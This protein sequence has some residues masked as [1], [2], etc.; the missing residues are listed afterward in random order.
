MLVLKTTKAMAVSKFNAS[1]L[2]DMEMTILTAASLRL[3]LQAAPLSSEN[4]LGVGNDILSS[5]REGMRLFFATQNEMEDRDADNLLDFA[6]F[7]RKRAAH[8]GIEMLDEYAEAYSYV[9]EAAINITAQGRV[10]GRRK[11]EIEALVTQS[12]EEEPSELCT[13][14]RK[15]LAERNCAWI[16]TTASARASSTY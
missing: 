13:L 4:L 7:V 8:K 5:K 3:Q 9:I 1:A 14:A 16:S 10:S 11:K 12:D 2:H 6:Y 15:I